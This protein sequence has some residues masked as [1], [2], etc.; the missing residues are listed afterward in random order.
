VSGPASTLAP[1]TIPDCPV[2]DKNAVQRTVMSAPA[3]TTH[4]DDTDAALVVGVGPGLGEA[5]ARRLADGGVGVGLL[6]RSE[7]YLEDLAADLPAATPIPADAT[8]D[9][10]AH[11]AV[12]RVRAAHGS[13]DALVVNVPGPDDAGGDA[14]EVSEA[15]LRACWELQVPTLLRFVRAAEDDLADGG[16][17]VVTNSMASRRVGSS[18]ARSGAR[19]ALRGTTLSLADGLSERGIHVVHLVVD[20]WLDKPA[21]RERYPDHD[22]WT[23]PDAVA[24]SVA[25]LI[26]QS[27]DAWIHELDVRARGDDVRR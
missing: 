15:D 13:V 19:F 17:V 7:E 24:D 23:D 5:V 1:S 21:L 8:A 4:M 16:T 11:R 20:G 27:G 22:T 10:A 26:G 25:H 18:P 12:E 9:G 2:P 3:P 14:T 6:A